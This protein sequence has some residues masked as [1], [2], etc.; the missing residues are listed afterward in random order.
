MKSDIEKLIDSI[1]KGRTSDVKRNVV[2]SIHGGLL[3]DNIDENLFSDFVRDVKNGTLYTSTDF[4]SGED[5]NYNI[6][7]YLYRPDYEPILKSLFLAK[8]NIGTPRAATGEF[9]IALLT[10]VPNAV[11]PTKGD[12]YNSE[13]G[14][15]NFKDLHPTIYCEADGK[16]LNRKMLEV[17]SKFGILPQITRKVA[18][19]NLLIANYVQ[20]FNHEFYRV[21]IQTEQLIEILSTWVSNLFPS[22]K[23]DDITIREVVMNSILN[24]QIC[25]KKWV[26][27]NMIFIHKYSKNRMEK[28]VLMKK[29]GQIFHLTQDNSEFVRLVYQG[30]ISFYADYFRMNQSGQCGF[31]INVN[32]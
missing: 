30:V 25:W 29:N 4:L 26:E 15:L 11:K 3:F 17:M 13:H 32:F 6:F 28:F 14:L 16:D 8:P 20:H 18:Y 12:F 2:S 22:Q 23:I 31:Y 9:E 10:T 1:I 7:D 24:D 21:R 5:N 19:G 27:Q